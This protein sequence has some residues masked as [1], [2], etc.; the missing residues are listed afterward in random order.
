MVELYPGSL[1]GKLWLEVIALKRV[2]VLILG[3]DR[4]HDAVNDWHKVAH[5]TKEQLENRYPGKVDVAYMTME[6]AQNNFHAAPQIGPNN[7]VP[8]VF[9][10]EELVL[11]GRK[12]SLDEIAGEVE[13]RLH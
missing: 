6:A 10:D 12:I 2:S 7:K 3:E 4:G 11:E 1:Q 13:K 8:M 5:Y 9:V